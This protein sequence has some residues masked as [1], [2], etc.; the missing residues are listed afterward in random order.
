MKNY[1]VTISRLMNELMNVANIEE[2]EIDDSIRD[3]KVQL[4]INNNHYGNIIINNNYYG[5]GK[6]SIQTNQGGDGS[7]QANKQM[8]GVKSCDQPL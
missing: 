2:K 7:C 1:L 5:S 3:Q 8:N 6:S 4:Q